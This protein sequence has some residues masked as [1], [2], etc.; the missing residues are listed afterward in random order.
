MSN[1]QLN[2]LAISYENKIY[3]SVDI[4]GDDIFFY[5][6]VVK[7]DFI[8]C[9][10]SKIFRFGFSNKTKSLLENFDS[11]EGDQSRNYFAYNI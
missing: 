4:L 3:I 5:N 11:F 6:S 10:E 1:L 8:P 7:S 2:R 9:D